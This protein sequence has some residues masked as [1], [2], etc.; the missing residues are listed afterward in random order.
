MLMATAA[1][2][3]TAEVVRL[4]IKRFDS[5]RGGNPTSE[6]CSRRLMRLDLGRPELLSGCRYGLNE[7]LRPMLLNPKSYP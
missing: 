5:H 6:G 1:N 4:V 2:M 7:M 3:A